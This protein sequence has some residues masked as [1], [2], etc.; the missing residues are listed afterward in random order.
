MPYAP[1]SSSFR[2]PQLRAPVPA[3]PATPSTGARI[4]LDRITA[5][6]RHNT[7]GQVVSSDRTPQGRAEVLFVNAE[8]KGDRQTVAADHWGRFQANLSS[9]TWLVY[10]KQPSGRMVYQQKVDVSDDKPS[11]PITLVSR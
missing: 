6:P 8:R 7:E 2:Q 5:A 3:Q 1:D 10:V 4:R 9:G 11:V